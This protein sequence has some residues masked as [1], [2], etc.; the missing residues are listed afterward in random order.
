MLKM[1]L[2]N[3][4][5][6]KLV[7]I[8]ILFCSW[9]L[10]A[11]VKDPSSIRFSGVPALGYSADSG[12]GFG[13][14][15]N[16]YTDEEGYAPYKSSLGLK[17]YLTTKGVNSHHLQYDQVRA[18]GLPL[19][20]VSRLGFYQTVEQNYCGRASDAQCDE[21]RAEIEANNLGLPKSDREEFLRL[22]YKN[23][24]MS[25][26]GD[27]F[28]RWL[29]W[30]DQ[31]KLELMTS[32]RGRYY[33]NRGFKE[34]GPYKNSLFAHDYKDFKT[35]GYL[36]TVETGL[37]LD[38][39]DNEASPTSGYWLESTVRGGSW[40][41]GSAWDYFGAN[42]AARFY[43]PLD[44]AHR[45]VVASQTI[46]D[47]I[48][49]D[50]PYDAMSRVGG[51]QALIDYS[52]IGGQNIGRGIREQRYVGRIKAIEQ[53]EFRYTFYSFD[54]FKQKFD[55]TGAAMG[56]LAMT[57]WDFSRFAK[58]MMSPYIGF[59]GGLRISWNKTFVIR[60]DLGVSP[61]EQFSPKFYLVVGNVF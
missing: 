48:V 60:A 29:L 47:V 56:D 25:L 13:V 6:I 4:F 44:D 35:D 36:S 16:M 59:G 31:A 1:V 21:E 51:S 57:A 3:R 54:L 28:A 30:R 40:L 12:F 45:V 20:L 22:Y 15:G 58:D 32:Y 26:F 18:F 49:G 53:L 10:K 37:M 17:V 7:S 19:R 5:S 9:G 11:S 46:G 55:L 39:R 50:L 24:Y 61:H 41:I 38:K 42:A 33:M 23:R 8:F 34:K 52:A 14:V 27:L 43:V 2:L